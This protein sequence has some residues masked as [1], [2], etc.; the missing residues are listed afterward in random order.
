MAQTVPASDKAILAK[1]SFTKCAEPFGIL[2]AG[3]KGMSDFTVL[4]TA[5]IMAELLDQNRDGK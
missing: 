4:E 3:H 2:V 5:K 1:N